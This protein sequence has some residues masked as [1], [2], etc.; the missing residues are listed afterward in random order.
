M[1]RI[2]IIAL[3]LLLGF[4][5]GAWADTTGNWQDN[6][7]ASWGSD[8]ATSDAFTVSTAAQFAQLAYMVVNE[9]KNFNHK[10]ITLAEDIDLSAHYW[11]PIG[12]PADN[13][14]KGTFDGAG[15][16]VSGM[17]ITEQRYYNG[18]FGSIGGDARIRNLKITNSQ[19]NASSNMTG[20]IVGFAEYCKIENCSVDS[21][22][23]IT[24]TANFENQTI[25][26]GGLVGRLYY[27]DAELWGCVCSAFVNGTKNV[28][29]LVGEIVSARV[30]ACLY[31]GSSVQG[32]DPS[33]TTQA[34]L[35]GNIS[36]G[37]YLFHNLYTNS[38]L[39]GKNGQ[40]RRGYVINLPSGINFDFGTP[41]TYDLSG[42][43]CYTYNNYPF[44]NYSCILYGGTMYSAAY[45]RIKFTASAPPAYV[46]DPEVTASTG[47]LSQSGE[48][49]EL[50]TDADDCT[51]SAT[52]ILT[53]WCGE[54][55]GTEETP[56]LVKT[57]DDLRWIAAYV[58]ATNSTHYTGKYFRVENDIEFDG[59]T[60]NYTAIAY[61]PRYFAGIFDGQNHT[62]SGINI[63]ANGPQGLFGSVSGATIKNLKLSASTINSTSS[64]AAG[65]IVSNVG[66]NGVTIENC[67]V[68]ESVTIES[69]NDSGGIVARTNAGFVIITG[70]TCGATISTRNSGSGVGGIVGTCGNQTG[71]LTT[72]TRITN[73]LYYGTSLTADNIYTGGVIGN[74]YTTSGSI[75]GQS[76]VIL[77][78]NYYT[79]PN[80]SVKG[81][82]FWRTT[83][84]S[85]NDDNNN[86]DITTDDSAIRVHAVTT[87]ADIEDMG[88]AGTLVE[89][90]ITLYVYGI[91]YGNGYY[92]HIL[93]LENAGDYTSALSVYDG[94]TFHVKLRGRTLYKDGS[95]NTLC[96]PFN[97]TGFTV[98]ED[99]A[100]CEKLEMDTSGK[101]DIDGVDYKTGCHDGKL[102]LFFKNSNSVEAGK[103]Y[104]I[105][106]EKDEDNYLNPMF[107]NVT[108]VSSTPAGVT[109]EDGTV[110]FVPTYAPFNRDYEDRSVLFVGAANRLYYPSGAGNISVKSFR[111]YFQ[112]HG[113]QMP[114]DPGDDYIP[115]GGGDVKAFVLDI[116]DDA[117]S[118]SEELKVKSVDFSDKGWYSLDG[119]KHE[120]K[121]SV[122]GIYVIG[123][124]KVVIK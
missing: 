6:R 15:H 9:D 58:N 14:F 79:Y 38:A 87:E 45:Q 68:S 116:E 106:W 34:A 28:G 75:A 86:Y 103:P 92:S 43:S 89:G 90:G 60:N 61:T 119:R 48:I 5:Q 55:I 62:I 88:T 84:G 31:T 46:L 8:Y 91:R 22:V 115:E 44:T 25:A 114:E 23:E 112:L 35:F 81:I 113:V 3:I 67:H 30:V 39:D 117:T 13:M 66:D 101:H 37:D 107:P 16:T 95:W 51:I 100:V 83:N 17:Y 24:S 93:A 42:I 102:Y 80:A 99:G 57:P 85:F 110:S 40:D 74:C 19:I 98:F 77:S 72:T 64:S 33:I 105:R 122:K 104:I 108:I 21:S 59:T 82:G 69:G 63:S 18:L 36:G 65:G 94:Q 118:L 71:S 10:T 41:T 123:G 4:V 26:T 54:G 27:G 111:A 73:C 76:I 11:L 20:A 47:T 49:Y 124:R 70:C 121:P 53:E 50:Y 29:G 52:T 97:Q 96:L 7:D 1:K 78:H 12:G 56:Y 2:Y 120:G 32:S 109:S